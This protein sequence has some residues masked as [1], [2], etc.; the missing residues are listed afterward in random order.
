MSMY[1]KQ[2]LYQQEGKKLISVFPKDLPALNALLSSKLRHF[3]F[4]P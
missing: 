3:G 1:K 2:A 4:A